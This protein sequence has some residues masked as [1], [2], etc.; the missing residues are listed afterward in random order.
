MPHIF[1][2]IFLKKAH[3]SN[4]SRLLSAENMLS[5]RCPAAIADRSEFCHSIR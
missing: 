5:S 2:R 1:L 3:D 4:E